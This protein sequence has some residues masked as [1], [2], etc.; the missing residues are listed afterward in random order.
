MSIQLQADL[1]TI[2]KWCRISAICDFSGMH[3]KAFSSP[4]LTVQNTLNQD[5][6]IKLLKPS[7]PNEDRPNQDFL[8]KEI[9]KKR[10]ARISFDNTEKQDYPFPLDD[11]HS[12][13]D[14]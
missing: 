14:L 11:T 7:E 1:I 12:Y 8:A 6:R 5:K 2:A 4:F 9:L 3:V 10:A 13:L